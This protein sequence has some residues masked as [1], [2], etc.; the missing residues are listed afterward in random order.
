MN[1]VFIKL[2]IYSNDELFLQIVRSELRDYDITHTYIGIRDTIIN[3]IKC[4]LFGGGTQLGGAT[5]FLRILFFVCVGYAVAMYVFH[6]IGFR[7]GFVLLNIACIVLASLVNSYD[8]M[9]PLGMQSYFCS[10]IAFSLGILIKGNKKSCK[11]GTFFALFVFSVFSLAVIGRFGT[12]SVGSGK[13]IN[14]FCMLWR[15]CVDGYCCG[16]FLCL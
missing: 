2:N 12:I 1:N 5:W 10:Y 7:Y 9:L 6:K 8:I 4:L 16:L 14:V 11:K 13:I 15:H 3:I